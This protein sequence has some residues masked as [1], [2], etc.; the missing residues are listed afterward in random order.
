[1]ELFVIPNTDK[2]IIWDT[3][4][5]GATEKPG[6]YAM[7][8]GSLFI[9]TTTWTAEVFNGTAF[10]QEG[11][12]A[13]G[14]YRWSY[15]STDYV[16]LT[17]TNAGTA[18]F[19]HVSGGTAGFIFSNPVSINAS[20]LNFT[21][22]VTYGVNFN[23]ATPVFT[24]STGRGNAFFRVGDWYT[25]KDVTLTA[26]HWVPVQ[27]NI[28]NLGTAAFDIAGIRSRV[29]TGA[30]TAG[31]HNN[32][33]LRQKY[34]HNVCAG[35]NVQASIS[36]DAAVTVQQLGGAGTP[37]SIVCGYFAVDGAYGITKAGSNDCSVLVAVNNN[38]AATSV[39]NVAVLMQ[40]GTGSTVSEILN[41]VCEH[42]T[43]TSGITIENTATGTAITTAL[44][45][46][47]VSK[48]I[49]AGTSSVPLV[50]D[51]VS[52]KFIQ[53]YTDC[54]ATSGESIGVYLRHYVTGAGGSGIAL[55]AFGTVS[56]V[57][58]V[59]ARGA[60]I[61]LNFGATGTVTGS[62]QA[63]TT[64]L[65]IANQAT[66]A[67]TLSAITTEIFSD[68]STSDPSGASLACIRMSNAGS[69]KD[70]VD[71]DCVALNFDSGWT[72]G[73]GNM[74]AKDNSPGTTPNAV[75]SIKVRMPDGELGYLYVGTTAL[76]A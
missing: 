44:T 56:D 43:A 76:T 7:G 61:S 12:T 31:N 16:T 74:I 38:T 17:I 67:G 30:N 5:P 60:H 57:A 14:V 36:I 3:T 47:G 54:G 28:K 35:S 49:I 26:D 73:D 68:G 52:P 48:V 10:G 6:G 11:E 51:T 34:A 45:M 39:D 64:T 66:Q 8:S 23:N 72:I 71:D 50:N 20:A 4:A 59:D 25:Q 1:M 37:G 15:D 18:T 40:N 24:A 53:Q 41:V 62:G 55:R 19:N 75:Y 33:Q 2:L 70:D 58:A 63:L 27:V 9:N 13:T 69:A 46:V 32:L 65:H 42:G 29:D 21:G 22:S